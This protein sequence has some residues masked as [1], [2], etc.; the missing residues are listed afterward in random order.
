MGPLSSMA[1]IATH[2]GSM[3]KAKDGSFTTAKGALVFP[4]KPGSPVAAVK[5][6]PV[7]SYFIAVAVP[8]VPLSPGAVQLRQVPREHPR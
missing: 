7:V 1:R 3:S 6:P 2:V 8:D 4:T 5:T